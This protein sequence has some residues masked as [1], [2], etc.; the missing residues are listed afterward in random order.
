MT[1]NQKYFNKLHKTNFK[2]VRSSI[3]RLKDVSRKDKKILIHDMSFANGDLMHVLSTPDRYKDVS[4]YF[5]TINAYLRSE[6]DT[7]E[8][9]RTLVYNI[10]GMARLME[11]IRQFHIKLDRYNELKEKIFGNE[12]A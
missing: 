10:G 4:D 7:Y 5:D 9:N 8:Y 12:S 1:S 2:K 6:T 11:I 3:R